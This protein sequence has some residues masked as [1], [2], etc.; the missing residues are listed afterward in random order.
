MKKIKKYLEY[1]STKV[2]KVLSE[3]R[4]SY[5]NVRLKYI[6][7]KNKKSKVLI[8]VFSACTRKG[9][10]A[11]YNYMR[12]LK[13]I[14]DN[15]LFILDDFGEDK[16][17]AYYLGKNLDNS[18]EKACV[19]LI[20]KIM[21][22]QKI[23]KIICVGSS[24]GGWAAINIGLNFENVNFIIGAPQ[25]LLGNYLKSPYLVKCREY[26]MGDIDDEKIEYL[27][28]YL[29]KKIA[30]KINQ[31]VFYLHYSN[32][33]HTYEDHVK[34]LISDIKQYDYKLIEEKK[35]YKNHDEVALYFPD[36]LVNSI[37]KI[38]EEK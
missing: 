31:S 36:F 37:N 15:K 21:K 3:K 38:I 16:R 8:V 14:E 34:Y 19:K 26:V 7:K 29:R 33:E 17:G 9:I 30:M 25:Y 12:T 2:E 13:K 18:I 1:I 28:Q 23:E 24:K 5:N 6:Y 20:E 27:N 11:R 35:D 4:F 22:E 32:M 10:K